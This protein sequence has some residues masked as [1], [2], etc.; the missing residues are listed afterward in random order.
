M[1]TRWNMYILYT[2]LSSIMVCRPQEKGLENIVIKQA[3]IQLYTL[4]PIYEEERNLAL[5]KGYE[6]LIDR[7][8]EKGVSDVL[9]F[10]RINVGKGQ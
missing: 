2:K 9:D 1:K 8:E 4:I 3:E 5:E 7:M 10:N 6:F